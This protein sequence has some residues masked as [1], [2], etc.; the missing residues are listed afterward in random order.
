M[1]STFSILAVAG[2][3]STAA[4]LDAR[5]L[6]RIGSMDSDIVARQDS[7]DMASCAQDVLSILGNIPTATAPLL[8]YFEAE[9]TALAT[10]TDLCSIP[11]VPAT[12]TS[13]YSS[14]QSVILSWYSSDSSQI[15]SVLTACSDLP[16]LESLAPL[17][18]MGQQAASSCFP[19][20][21]SSAS[22]TKTGGATTST[23]SSNTAP[24]TPASTTPPATPA[25]APRATAGAVMAAA[26]LI[27]AAILM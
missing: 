26:G 7:S 6:A 24:T 1:H 27:G 8:S 15:N 22:V 2:L 21:S 19:G 12:L 18:T 9:A 3:A 10:M 17:V 23:T 16:G 20:S 13:A 25:A 14:Y 11:A 5:N 4:A